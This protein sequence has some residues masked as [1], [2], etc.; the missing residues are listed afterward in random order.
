MESETDEMTK[1]VATYDLRESIIPFALLQ[2]C[3]HL[4][5]MKHGEA[6]EVI[7]PDEN[8]TRVL[9]SIL[10][11]FKYESSHV[12]KPGTTAPEF[13]LRLRKIEQ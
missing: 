3:N 5:A 11:R 2:I 10:A 8:I 6:I 12:D 7:C 1:T 9:K 13:C 4:K